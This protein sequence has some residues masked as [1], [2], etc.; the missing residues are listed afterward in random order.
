LEPVRE[1]PTTS[2]GQPSTAR[3]ETWSST[4]RTVSVRNQDQTAITV[5]ESFNRGW[6]ATLDGK[7]LEPVVVDG[8]KQAWLVPA[9]SAGTVHL[10]FEP[11]GAFR[12]SI[13]VGLVLAGLLGLAAL[14]TLALWLR[15]RN[16]D[17]AVPGT[18]EGGPGRP[19][20]SPRLRRAGLL[21]GVVVL[22]AVS[23]PLAIGTTAG[24]LA[25]R[26]HAVVV[27]AG[28]VAGALAAALVA[29]GSADAIVVAPTLSD[30]IVALLVGG[31]CGAVLGGREDSEGGS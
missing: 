18:D 3:V 7:R 4:E 19:D 9:A 20:S 13:V 24:Y 11:Q 23:V 30:A 25:R 31:V 14:V 10:V 29:I 12:S 5:P 17:F 8:W 6:R 21:V 1:D 2:S 27:A 22:V 16:P 26:A 28:C 15:R